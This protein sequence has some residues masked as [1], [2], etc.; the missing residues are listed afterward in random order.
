MRA[1]VR[2][3][4][5]TADRKMC[6]ARHEL[7][8]SMLV[9]MFIFGTNIQCGKYAW[10][11]MCD[12]ENIIIISEYLIYVRSKV[13]IERTLTHHYCLG[14]CMCFVYV[15]TRLHCAPLIGMHAECLCCV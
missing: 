2:S 10:R 5:L 9:A 6:H 4:R 3:R 8:A 7:W 1:C 14:Y 12:V 13:S 15:H 11:C